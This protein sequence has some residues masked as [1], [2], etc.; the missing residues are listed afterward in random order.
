VVLLDGN[1]A[2]PRL[3]SLA[4]THRGGNGLGDVLEGRTPLSRTLVR[5]RRSN[6][7]LLAATPPRGDAMPLLASRQF[8]DLLAHL[9]ARCD[10]LFMVAPPVL[11]SAST[12]ALARQADAVM[13][14]ARADAHPRP[15]VAAAVDML[16]AIP[17]PPIGLVLAA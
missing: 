16:A 13:L 3:L 12:Q 7:L 1:L 14:V 4:A 6:L 17:A 11:A 2:M 10:L 5:D 8:R 9:R 15:A